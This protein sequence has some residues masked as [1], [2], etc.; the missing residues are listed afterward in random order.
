M[1]RA[2]AFLL[3]LAAALLPAPAAAY[4]E[5]TEAGAR[6]VSMGRAFVAVAD[7]ATA[8]YW[9]PAG[10]A[11][12]SR[13]EVLLDYS[14]PF[15]VE[16]LRGGFAGLA[17]PAAWGAMGAGWHH[18]GVADVVGEDLFYLSFARRSRLLGDRPWSLRYGFTVKAA[19]I[20]Y[21]DSDDADYG[22]E[23]AFTGDLGIGLDGPKGVSLGYAVRNI[24]EPEF[25][26]VPGG[27]G[28]A[29]LRRHDAGIAYRW[30]SDSKLVASMQSGDDGGMELRIGGEVVFYNVL[31][32]RAGV[33]GS[34]FAGGVGLASRRWR[35]ESAFLTHPDLGVSYRVSLA[36]PF[37]PEEAP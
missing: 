13:P 2:F 14:R 8:L 16:G 28:T 36:I 18:L 33:T 4:F 11:R 9:N 7:D 22:S 21:A 23:T 3:A 19:R 12:I 32:V 27:G 34:R 17:W 35:L 10:L 25:D 31:Y 26:F 20:G 6:A 15:V 1:N 29:M 24:A 30:H 37:G 5:E